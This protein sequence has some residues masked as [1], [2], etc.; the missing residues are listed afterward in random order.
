[1]KYFDINGADILYTYTNYNNVEVRT[2]SSHHKGYP[3]MSEAELLEM[4]AAALK[5]HTA[6]GQA[7][8][9]IRNLLQHPITEDLP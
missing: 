2:I 5:Q 4:L 3:P 9:D 1:M 7:I 8:R 6:L